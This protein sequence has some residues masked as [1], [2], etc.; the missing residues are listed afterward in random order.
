MSKIEWTDE[1]WNVVTGCE[2]ESPG[3]KNCYAAAMTRRLERMGQ[4]KYQG[5]VG[6]AH[7]NGVVKM[8]PDVLRAPL[9]WRKPRKIFVCSMSDLFHPLVPF[10]FIDKV[11]AV[12]A[13]ASQHTFQ[14]LTKRPWRMREYFRRLQVA[15]DQ[16][17]PL[18]A[19]ESFTPAD[20]L[21]CRWLSA[22][23][24]GGPASGYHAGGE[25]FKAEWPLPNV[26][27]GTS[28][29]NQE[30][31]DKRIPPLLQCPRQFGFCRVSRCWKRS[32]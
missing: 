21:N 15:A 25:A 11:F 13:L 14:V 16:H 32:T 5:L 19:N 9:R 18:T 20:V 8:H 4:A 31:A 12:M 26:W 2:Y 17:A 23:R 7:F 6:K 22:N 10:G 27:L 1:T 24:V 3:C 29:E 28:V 30:M